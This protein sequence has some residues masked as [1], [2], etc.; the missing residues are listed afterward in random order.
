MCEGERMDG[1][2]STVSINT[3]LLLSS[4]GFHKILFIV[5]VSKKFILGLQRV[6]GDRDSERKFPI[7]G[8]SNKL[9]LVQALFNEHVFYTN[10]ITVASSSLIK[11]ERK[12]LF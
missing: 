6:K 4:P 11:P 3:S 5:F 1:F 12:H 8:T 9:N 7:H 2:I 10:K